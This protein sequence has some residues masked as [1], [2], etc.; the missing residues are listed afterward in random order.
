MSDVGTTAATGREAALPA[1]ARR[2][3]R[4]GAQPL[5]WAQV[6][7]G[8][9]RE[10]ALVHLG[11]QHP[12]AIEAG[13]FSRGMLMNSIIESTTAQR[14]RRRRAPHATRSHAGLPAPSRK[15][16]TE[17][18]GR[19]AL[20]FLAGAGFALGA[21]LPMKAKAAPFGD[22]PVTVPA[23]IQA[24]HFDRGGESVGYH[25]RSAGN[26][27]G[28]FRPAENVDIIKTGAGNYVINNFQTGEWL[29]YTI[30]VPATGDYR[31][32]LRA[33]TAYTS[34][35]FHIKVDGKDVTGPLTIPTTGGW[36]TYR[37]VGKESIRLAAGRRVLKV[38]ANHEYFNL[39]A[40]RIEREDVAHAR[41]P[42][43]PYGGTPW[44]VPGLIQAEKFDHGGEGI[45]YHDRVAGNAGK[46]YRQDED[47]DIIALD[48]GGRV[49]NNF[50]TGEWLRY[51]VDVAKTARYDIKLKVSSATTT[52]HFHVQIDG[53]DVT[54]K[55][56][57]PHTGGWD[58]FQW[59]GK[60]GVT[61]QAGRHVMKVVVN[62][63]YFN[64]NSIRIS[65]TAPSSNPGSN[66]SPQPSA[67]EFFCTFQS[68][69]GECGFGVQA[70]DGSRV[71]IVSGGRDG[72]TAVRLRTMPG[73]SNV[74]G[75][76]SSERAD[77]SLSQGSTD[78]AQGK[79]A[80][81]AHSVMFPSDYVSP[82]DGFGVVMDFHHTGSSGQANFHVDSSRWDGQLHFRGYGGSQDQ[83]EYGTVIGPV[84]KNQWYD[85][86]YH[87][88]WSSGTDGF[89]R[90]WVNGK[91]KLDHRGPTL[92]AG[93]GCYLK[94]ANYH[95]PFGEASAVI[96]DRVIRGSSWQAVSRT[97]L[98]GVN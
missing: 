62:R 20:V 51:T 86:V 75:S 15:R 45:G 28:V 52:G 82:A 44:P 31:I 71:S 50:Q 74:F 11:A 80:W 65:E 7:A 13:V 58:Q 12:A 48:G 94:L 92:Y 39:K 90:A 27:G 9:R 54:G 69:P 29:A 77:L 40:I 23:T 24:V 21:V 30:D 55:V 34:S 8:A 59:V 2:R 3:R 63:Q 32:E 33:A 5:G 68:S 16:A 14:M 1:L 49:I 4:A 25:D 97:T 67:R 78:C 38:F 64:L 18:L 37:W 72:S 88:R 56:A 85:F 73:D 42:A 98:E 17:A 76:G 93:Q 96:H 60:S 22:G 6:P 89:M 81:W 87:V 47:V 61:L 70:K 36:T 46:A 26:A 19:S 66:P 35:G 10:A 83:N 95:S 91:K 53:Q 79:E 43:T 84:A 57:V 41:A